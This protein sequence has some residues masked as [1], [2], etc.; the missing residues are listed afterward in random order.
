MDSLEE[1]YFTGVSAC[2]FG[3][4]QEKQQKVSVEKRQIFFMEFRNHTELVFEIEPLNV[5]GFKKK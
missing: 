2:K 1:G 4:L 3:R 5:Q